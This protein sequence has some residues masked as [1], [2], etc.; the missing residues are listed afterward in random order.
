[1]TT[2]SLITTILALVI[3]V[4]FVAISIRRFG[5]QRSYSAFA[6]K[7]TEAVPINGHTHLWSIVTFIAAL[8]LAFGMIEQGEGHPWQALGFFAPFYL[9]VVSFTP[10]Y[11]DQPGDDE[12]MRAKRKRQRIIHYIGTI[13]CAAV[14]AVW[15]FLAG[16]RGII[17]FSLMA[18]WVAGIVTR[19]INGSL[20]FWCEM[21]MF[22]AVYAAR[23]IG[24]I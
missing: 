22:A 2:F 4:G 3:F 10:E 15:L 23:L 19:S 12:K 13:L 18:A 7:W 9:M 8:L 16:P 11:Q 5:W 21:A 6:A 20:I 14:S 24:G 17:F 1:M